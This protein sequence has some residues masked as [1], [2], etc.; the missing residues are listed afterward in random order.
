MKVKCL[1]NTG[2][3][4]SKNTLLNMGCTIYTELPLT[5][6]EIY[7]VYGQIISRG[8]LKYLIKGSKENLPSWYPA[9]IFEVVDSLLPFEWYFKYNK[10]NEISAIWGYQELVSDDKYLEK[11]VERE[12]D[13]IRI[14][15]KRKKE[16]DEFSE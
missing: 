4:F 9:E 3:G 10:T 8:I 6:D 7:I 1:F 12:D 16:I 2:I 5:I 15:L 13:A 11:L 14:F